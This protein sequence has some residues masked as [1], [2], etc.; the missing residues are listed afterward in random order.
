MN[1]H[2][3]TTSRCLCVACGC[4]FNSVKAFDRHRV[5]E[6]P[7]S[8]QCLTPREMGERGMTLNSGGFWITKPRQRDRVK[9]ATSRI[10]A[11]LRETPWGHQGGEL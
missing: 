5:G 10:S 3:L 11:A 9:T 7:N 2:R 1:S 4:Y 8:R 6:F